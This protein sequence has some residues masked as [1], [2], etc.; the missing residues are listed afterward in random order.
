MD[1]KGLSTQSLHYIYSDQKGQSGQSL[2]YSKTFLK[3]PPKRRPKY[4]FSRLIIAYCRSK[5]LQNAPMEHSAVQ[6]T[7]IKIPH[8]FLTFV[9]SIFEWLL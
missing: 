9:L 7:C 3:Q 6:L 8:G 2:S 5:V 1:Q 4:R